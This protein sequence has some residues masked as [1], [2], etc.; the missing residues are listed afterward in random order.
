MSFVRCMKFISVLLQIDLVPEC[1][2]EHT[3]FGLNQISDFR[4]AQ[5]EAGIHNEVIEFVRNANRNGDVNFSH[6]HS[7]IRQVLT[8]FFDSICALALGN[9]IEAWLNTK[10]HCESFDDMFAKIGT[11]I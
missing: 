8:F 5:V 4:Q 3:I 9:N 1:D 10:F 2:L 6:I 11:L 7:Q